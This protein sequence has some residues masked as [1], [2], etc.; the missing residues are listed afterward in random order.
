VYQDYLKLLKS[1]ASLVF[2]K[3]K[4]RFI[5]HKE[6]N[7]AG[8]ARLLCELNWCNALAYA[9]IMRIKAISKTSK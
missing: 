9:L 4:S 7:K 6:V 5:H 3:E 8:N 1:K 2:S